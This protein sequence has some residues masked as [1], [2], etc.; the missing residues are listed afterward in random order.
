MKTAIKHWR[1][2]LGAW[3]A[4]QQAKW[5]LHRA[6][7]LWLS[8][9]E[10][11]LTDSILQRH[12]LKSFSTP[13][14]HGRSNMDYVLALESVHY[15]GLLDPQNL[16][17]DFIE[18][19]RVV[20][21]TTIVKHDPIYHELHVNG[22]EFTHHDVLES[23]AERNSMIRKIQRLEEYRGKKNFVFFYHYRISP[24][25]HLDALIEK[26]KRFIP[27][28]AI[29]GKS[30]DLVIFTQ[31]IVASKEDRGVK[32]T[33]LQPHIHLFECAT[34]NPWGGGND[35]DFWAKNDEDLVKIMMDRC[36]ELFPVNS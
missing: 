13:F 5:K 4:R 28:Y 2:R 3:K 22:H 21:S 10:N 24:D 6:K 23:D 19:K 17:H 9:G 30:C 33:L 16:R 29:Q 7:T 18:E 34:L 15:N 12:G 32:Y 14:S 8:L 26:A 27:F 36:R 11:C 25:F 1:M 20:R 35:D 31:N